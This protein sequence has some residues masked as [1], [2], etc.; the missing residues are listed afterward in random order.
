MNNGQDKKSAGSGR[1]SKRGGPKGHHLSQ[2][3][4]NPADMNILKQ[5]LVDKTNSN[6]SKGGGQQQL[7]SSIGFI[8][9]GPLQT[10]PSYQ[11]SLKEQS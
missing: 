11:S 8:P 4:S 2:G 6:G 5:F 1:N 10:Q 3:S 7:G 9:G